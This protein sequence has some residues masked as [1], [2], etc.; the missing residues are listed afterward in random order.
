MVWGKPVV[1]EV[2]SPSTAFGDYEG[3][4]RTDEVKIVMH[5]KN[6][7]FGAIVNNEAKRPNSFIFFTEVPEPYTGFDWLENQCLPIQG[8]YLGAVIARQFNSWKVQTAFPCGAPY[9]NRMNA[10]VIH[11]KHT[12]WSL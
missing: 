4:D 12:G 5:I 9:Y 8:G 6:C 3:I 7:E 10:K 1:N 11:K 2:L